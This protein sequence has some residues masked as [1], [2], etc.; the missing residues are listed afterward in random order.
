MWV[1]IHNKITVTL[2][3]PMTRK[4]NIRYS[5]LISHWLCSCINSIPQ[6]HSTCD[7]VWVNPLLSLSPFRSCFTLHTGITSNETMPAAVET[8]SGIITCSITKY[9]INATPKANL[10]LWRENET[11]SL[12]IKVFIPS[13]VKL[14]YLKPIVG[15]AVWCLTKIIGISFIII[16]SNFSKLSSKHPKFTGKKHKSCQIKMKSDYM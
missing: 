14:L 1:P 9:F 16:S 13:R 10:S 2:L 15:R 5:M 8:N 7:I 4:Q 3:Q 11:A 6:R 12:A